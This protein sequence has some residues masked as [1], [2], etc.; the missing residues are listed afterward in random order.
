[1]KGFQFGK[2]GNAKKKKS[3]GGSIREKGPK[4]CFIQ[5]RGGSLEGPHEEAV[6]LLKALRRGKNLVFTEDTYL[7]KMGIEVAG[8]VE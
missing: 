4:K 6:I 5:T 7:E 8:G 3:S 2:V 1:M